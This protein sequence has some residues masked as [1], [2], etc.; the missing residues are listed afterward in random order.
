MAH[1]SSQAPQYAA[2]VMN[3]RVLFVWT[4]IYYRGQ[5]EVC[6]EIMP[7]LAGPA[8]VAGSR[9]REM[10]AQM[11]SSSSLLG[12]VRLHVLDPAVPDGVEPR[13]AGLPLSC[14][15]QPGHQPQQEGTHRLAECPE[16]MQLLR[17]ICAP[18]A[19]RATEELLRK[20][21]HSPGCFKGSQK[22]P[23]VFLPQKWLG[24]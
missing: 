16:S 13:K 3:I 7:W 9:T 23:S 19:Q 12:A 22:A 18:C 10:Q 24:G 8:P 14:C 2:V 5:Q 4:H 1:G 6:W 17:H 20:P 21:L 11:L 15:R